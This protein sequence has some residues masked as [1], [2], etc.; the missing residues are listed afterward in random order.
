METRVGSP[1][2]SMWCYPRQT[3]RRIV[4]ADPDRHVLLIAAI[5]G[6][7]DAIDRAAI[8]SLG[9]HL[10]L[11]A[12]LLLSVV[13]GPVLGVISL[14]V[15]GFFLRLTGEWIGGGAD[16]HDLRCAIAWSSVI[17]I[18]A[19]VLWIPE[20][21]LFG[22][23]LFT[24]KR[25]M[26]HASPVLTCLFWVFSAIEVIVGV[27]AFVVFLKCLSEVQRFSVWKALAN[28]LMAMVILVVSFLA[29]MCPLIYYFWK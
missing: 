25:P 22:K 26:I 8:N 10:S 1:W 13:A 16:S 5:G 6:I 23:E 2:I 7:G 9:S 18:W 19:M 14:Y 15:V 29:I 28:A 12:I 3:I 27:W 17:S 21:L 4:E 20:V 24:W 11:E